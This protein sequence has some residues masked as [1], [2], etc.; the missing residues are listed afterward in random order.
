MKKCIILVQFK[1]QTSFGFNTPLKFFF[2]K[3]SECINET[4]HNQPTINQSLSS[5]H[6]SLLR[7]NLKQQLAKPK[8][9]SWFITAIKL[10]MFQLR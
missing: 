2:C 5:L 10:I 9:M 7:N 6:Q 3:R 1:K 8:K 4:K